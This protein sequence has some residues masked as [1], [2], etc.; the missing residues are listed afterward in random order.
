V[1][2]R[3]Q[4]AAFVAGAVTATAVGALALPPRSADR[5]RTLDTFAQTLAYVAN[6]Y[7]DQTD[8]RRLL[9]GAARGLV[10][11]LDQHSA[12]L[13]PDRYR[14]LRQD[15]EGEFG[16]VGLTLGPGMTDGAIT[17]PW[18]FV[19]EVVA[20]S[21]A[22]AAGLAVDDRVVAI[23]G[24]PTTAGGK[25]RKDAGAWEA[26]LRGASGTRLAVTIFR[27]GWPRPREFSLVR[28]QV[29]MPSVER[30]G[31][32]AGI[33]YVAV[34]RFAESTAA[35]VGAALTA[36]RGGGHLG[37][38]ILDLRTNP[39]GLLDQ[40]VAVA[41][42][43]LDEGGIVTIRGRQGAIEEHVAH[44]P[45]TWT[46]FPI[47]VL[48]DGGTASAAEIVAGALQD[49]RRAQI[50]GGTTFGKGSVQTFFDL[51]DGSGLKLTTARFYT[52]AGKSLEGKGITPD[53]PVDAFAPI[54]ISAGIDNTS[55]DAAGVQ[56]A[57]SAGAATAND[58]RIRDRLLDDPP[59]A[60][61]LQLARRHL[62]PSK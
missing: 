9:H 24:E 62:S 1:S 56:P 19:D 40:G 43:F 3:A 48:V 21:P 12:F 49:G 34:G 26:A 52:P 60:A 37:A 41:D 17:E 35:D 51:Q 22:E 18:P 46:G 29:K 45:G 5:Y 58:A 6:N 14:R 42:L 38:L 16:G 10:G 23:G 4:A 33:G 47:F 15:T 44:K 54:E 27:P 2:A 28:A 7:V 55:P 30:L 59:Y 31:V 11:T 25:E 50:V 8:E 20:G 61:A 13:P 36:L 32:E 39:G 53:V 57:A